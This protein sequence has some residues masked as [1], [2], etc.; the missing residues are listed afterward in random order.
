MSTKAEPRRSMRRLALLA[1]VGALVFAHSARAS[2]PGISAQASPSSGAAPLAVTLTATGDAISYVWD[3]GDGSPTAAGASVQHTYTAYGRYTAV[4]TGTAADGESAQASV[5]VT[6]YSLSLSAPSPV[7]YGRRVSFRGTLRPAQARATV[8]LTRDGH[9]IATAHTR[10]NGG[11]RV[12]ARVRLP[13]VYEA[14]FG[15]VASNVRTVRVRPLL[16][17]RVSGAPLVGSPLT[18]TARVRPARA[19]RIRVVA[20]RGGR[21][22]FDGSAPGT[23]RVRLK[24]A[25]PRVYRVRVSIVPAAGFLGTAHQLRV[26]VSMPNLSWGARGPSVVFLEQRLSTLHYALERV[27]SVYGQDDYDAVIAFQKVNGLSRTGSVDRTVWR[28]LRTASIPTPRYRSGSHLEVDKG[29]QV[30]FDVRGGQVARAIQVSTGA[31]GNTPVGVWHVYSKEPG[32]NAL[33][34]YYSMYFLRGFAVH[35]YPEVPPYPAS[36]GCVRV[37]LWAAYSLYAAHGYGTTVIIY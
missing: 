23:A 16:T 35:G 9:R 3:F 18:V 34:M 4:V 31:T 19:G 10:R 7:R 25:S 1:F 6:A 5:E 8:M 27:D 15:D 33:S 12:R 28:R 29:R 20:R 36:H 14:A 13:G 17:V 30:L 22:V 11:F 21:T 24:T 32:F 26:A 37:P 2:V